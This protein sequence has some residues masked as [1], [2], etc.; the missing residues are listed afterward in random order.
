MGCGGSVHT[1]NTGLGLSPTIADQ[2]AVP[3]KSKIQNQQSSFINPAM[4]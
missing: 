4:E 2:L 3:P 1:L